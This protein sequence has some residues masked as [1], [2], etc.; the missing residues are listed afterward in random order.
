M[1]NTKNSVI[2]LLCLFGLLFSLLTGCVSSFQ[3]RSFP[4]PVKSSLI[5][6]EK[7]VHWRAS[8]SMSIYPKDQAQASAFSFTW[9]QN[10]HNYLLD[11]F[12]PL[13]L[14]SLH[15]SGDSKQVTLWQSRTQKITA[16][17]PEALISTQ[18][19]Y[20]LPVTGLYYWIRGLADPRFPMTKVLNTNGYLAKLEQQGWIIN[21]LNFNNNL[22][23]LIILNNKLMRIKIAVTKWDIL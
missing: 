13:G 7:L 14:A 23:S 20:T 16:K 19:G 2:L 12:A 11:F 18:L 21:Y 22:P 8:G 15:V 1:K 17:T 9:E 10:K 6:P 4:T 5:I 3:P